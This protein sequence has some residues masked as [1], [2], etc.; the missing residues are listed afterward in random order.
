MILT[1]DVGNTGVTCGLF[2]NDTIVKK[3]SMTS[4]I[5]LS[6]K[7][8]KEDLSSYIG[9][10]KIEGAIISSV[11]E[12]INDR[13][14]NAVK[15]VCGVIPIKLTHN[16]NMPIK[17]NIHNNSELGADRIANGVKGWDLYKQGVI[18]VDLG[19]ATTFDIVNSN[20]EFIGGLIAPGIK[21]QLDSL[22]K[23]TEKLPIINA[24]S[25]NTSI[26]NNTK[27]AILAGV[28]KG[29]AAMID[30]MIEQ[31]EQELKEKMKIILTGG[32]SDLISKYITHPIDLISKNI[33]LEGLLLLYRLN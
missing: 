12:E 14:F 25:I 1:I 7:T 19:T 8:Y 29:S 3:F 26:G 5:K 24:M 27:D 6:E 17:L 16:S 13:L 18:I 10:I 32:Y 11:V 21:T 20:G 22:G 33:T 2:D 30:G 31:V 4:D 23:A 28:I 15:S 9:E